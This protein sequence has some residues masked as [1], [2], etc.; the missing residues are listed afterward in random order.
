VTIQI[1][2]EVT[3]PG[4]LKNVLILALLLNAVFVILD[5]SGVISGLFLLYKVKGKND[6]L[7]DSLTF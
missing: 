2:N 6:Y 3:F 7:A 1:C 5:V 4:T